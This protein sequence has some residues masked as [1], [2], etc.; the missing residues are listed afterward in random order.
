LSPSALAKRL[1]DADADILDGVVPVD[2]Q[3]AFCLDAQV[4][5]AVACDLVQHVVEEADAGGEFGN[6][7]TVEI[8]DN[9]DLRFQGVA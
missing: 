2:V 6:A 1:A 5:H 4:E 9:A 3:I 7:A 8:E